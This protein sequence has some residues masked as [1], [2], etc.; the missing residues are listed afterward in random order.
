M[1]FLRQ[2]MGTL[3]LVAAVFGIPVGATL[4]AGMI[5]L[6]FRIVGWLTLCLTLVL[7][8]LAFRADQHSKGLLRALRAIRNALFPQSHKLTSNPPLRAMKDR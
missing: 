6:P 1:N 5:G 4:L 8:L 3:I 2:I 7:T